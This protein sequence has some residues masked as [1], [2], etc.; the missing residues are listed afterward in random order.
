MIKGHRKEKSTESHLFRRS[1]HVDR[2]PRRFRIAGEIFGLERPKTM[3]G[4]Q[5]LLDFAQN[6]NYGPDQ[7]WNS[8]DYIVNDSTRGPDYYRSYRSA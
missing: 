2:E 6:D 5:L 8:Q 3:R 1:H 4:S 7:D